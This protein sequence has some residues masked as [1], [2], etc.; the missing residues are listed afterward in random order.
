MP[1]AELPQPKNIAIS[2]AVCFRQ[3]A[4]VDRM[5]KP[6][7]RYSALRRTTDTRGKCG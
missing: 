6:I 7:D 1:G 4:F 5:A 3:T 2:K